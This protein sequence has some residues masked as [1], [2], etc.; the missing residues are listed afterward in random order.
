MNGYH[1]RIQRVDNI[2]YD[3]SDIFFLN[4][5]FPPIRLDHACHISQ[6]LK[7]IFHLSHLVKY[8]M[9][10]NGEGITVISYFS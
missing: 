2:S 3:T 1:A 4:H 5:F 8:L 6:F 10:F 9:V 7:N